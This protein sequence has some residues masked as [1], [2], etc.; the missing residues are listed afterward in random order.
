MQCRFTL[1]FFTDR[2]LWGQPDHIPVGRGAELREGEPGGGEI[3]LR[4]TDLGRSIRSGD[5]ECLGL[6]HRR[7]KGEPQVLGTGRAKQCWWGKV[8]YMSS[9]NIELQEAENTVPCFTI[10]NWRMCIVTVGKWS[11]V[12]WLPSEMDSS[13]NWAWL[14]TSTTWKRTSSTWRSTWLSCEKI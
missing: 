2:K 12:K 3:S 6:D 9:S 7:R 10:K 11:S 14:I 5:R 1:S 13:T 8:F 4:G